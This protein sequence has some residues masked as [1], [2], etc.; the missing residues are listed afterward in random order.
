M[1]EERHKQL[2]EASWRR[3]L[4]PSEEAELQLHLAAHPDKQLE[5]EDEL[6]LSFALNN[7]PNAPLASNFTSQVLQAVDAEERRRE[8]ADSSATRPAWFRRWFPRF[9]SVGILIASVFAGFNFYEAH[10]RSTATEM[11]SVLSDITAAFPS[12]QVLED[13][14]AIHELRTAPAFS[15][16]ELVAALL[17]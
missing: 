16:E 2:I 8:R 3:A 7:L 4:S 12:P 1:N 11:V 14:D 6:A 17:N 9:A 15:D 13:F 5:W 10:R